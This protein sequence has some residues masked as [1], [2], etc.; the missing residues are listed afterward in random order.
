[1]S[2]SLAER[3]PVDGFLRA[4]ADHGATHVEWLSFLKQIDRETADDVDLHLIADNYCTHKHEKVV[5]S[6]TEIGRAI[7]SLP[8]DE[9]GTGWPIM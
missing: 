4:A 1:M 7:A 6:S 8:P 9:G 3:V 5:T 2:S